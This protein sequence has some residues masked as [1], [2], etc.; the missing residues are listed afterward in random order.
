MKLVLATTAAVAIGLVV[1]SAASAAD[2]RVEPAKACYGSGEKV[3]LLG[4]GFTPSVPG[5]VSV[6][7][8]GAA[9]GQL[10]TDV[11]GS[12][13]GRLTLGQRRGQRTS[14]YTATDSTN[15]TL[16]ASTQIT[17]SEVRVKVRPKDGPPGR[18]LTIGAAGFTTGKRLWAHIRKGRFRRNIRIGTLKKPCR[19]LKLRRSLLPRGASYGVYTVQFDTFRRYKARRA[20][21]VGFTLTVRQVPVGAAASA[22]SDWSRIF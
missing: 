9:L 21:S 16:T 22:G 7:R 12:V 5:G 19:K 17:V 1:T 11:G 8:D 13:N 3:N 15:P 20:V 4:G 14:V 2:L 10:S 18:R 6:T